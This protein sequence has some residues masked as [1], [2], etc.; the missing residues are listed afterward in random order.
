[1]AILDR[2]PELADADRLAEVEGSVRFELVSS[3][4]DH[5]HTARFG[6]GSVTLDPDATPDVTISAD[7]VDFVRLVTGQSNAALL[8][9]G[10]RLGIT[11]REMLALAVGT[12]FPVPGSDHTSVD[13]TALDPVEVATVVATT[14][15]RQMRR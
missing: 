2:L 7:V 1:M 3:G 14:S 10:G 6:D 15:T 12:V 5:V 13:P 4:R 11:G 9:L 8:Y